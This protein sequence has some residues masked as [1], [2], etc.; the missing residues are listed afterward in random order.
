[1]RHCLFLF[2]LCLSYFSNAQ[3]PD[4]FR[5][6]AVARDNLGAEVVN[7]NI[8]VQISILDNSS[9]GTVL[10]RETHTV[11]TNQ[12]GLFSLSIGG[13]TPNIGTMGGVN[14]S[15]GFKYLKVE[16]D[17]TGGTSYSDFS[18]SQLL[19]VPYA[20]HAATSGT[21]ILPNG[22]AFGNTSFWN[23]T[24]WVV[25]SNI[26]YNDGARI[27]IGTTSPQQKLDVYGNINLS[28]DSSIMFGNERFIS[29]IGVKNLF[30]GDSS[31]FSNSNGNN[32]TFVGYIAGRDNL[33]GNQNTFIGSETGVVN[34]AGSMNTFVGRRAGYSNTIATENT[35]LGAY[36]GQNN[37]EGWHN[38]FL[39]VT[40]GS[41]NTTGSENSFLGAHAGYLNSEGSFNTFVGNFAG[42][43]NVLGNFNT[44]LGFE[45]DVS[46]ASFNNATAIGYQAVA[47]ASNSVQIGNSNVTFI[48]G[49]VGWSTVSD[50]RLK[51]DIQANT[52]GLEFINSLQTVNY[53]YLAEGQKGIR[54]SGFIAQDVKA[55]LDSMNIEFSGL[56]LP[57]SNSDYYSIRY[58]EFVVPL[59]RAV[60]E[61]DEKINKLIDENRKL[62][63]HILRLED[64]LN[65]L[66][67]END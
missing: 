58:S 14:W 46:A 54:Y 67:H 39:G 34:S 59:V 23:G 50:R 64:R 15:T 6:Q 27:G 5:Y 26:L 22:T 41:Y 25:N 37:T 24:D 12:F 31:G 1:M 53:E 9:T 61:Q 3:A 63:D 2:L 17:F 36:A 29:R 19:S 10:Y 44:T 35:F 52:L 60:Q 8:G 45:A 13:G 40:T 43:T 66:D 42:I 16:A 47:N 56:V 62:L 57:R 65:K 28:A 48:G 18:S 51:R 55:V 38:S 32:N 33:F 7:S 20:L 4:L 11:T 30:V 21:P 49:Q